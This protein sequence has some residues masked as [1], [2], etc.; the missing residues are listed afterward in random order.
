MSAIGLVW[1]SRAIAGSDVAMTVESMFSMKRATA[2]MS[3]MVR[4][5]GTRPGLIP[6]VADREFAGRQGGYHGWTPMSC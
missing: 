1:M 3:G 6:D 2:N 5:K 4:F